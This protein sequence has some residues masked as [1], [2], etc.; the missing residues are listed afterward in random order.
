MKRTSI[1][2]AVSLAALSSAIAQTPADDDLTVAFKTCR[3]HWIS[4]P[5]SMPDGKT[6]VMVG[7]EKGWEQCGLVRDAYQ[8]SAAAAQDRDH[9]A[10]VEADRQRVLDLAKKL[11]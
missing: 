9:A 11:Q 7:W 8:K 3:Q 4:T 10:Q 5:V 1:A 2:L 6:P